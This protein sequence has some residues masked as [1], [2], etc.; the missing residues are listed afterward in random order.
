MKIRLSKRQGRRKSAS[1]E[2]L[3]SPNPRQRNSFSINSSNGNR[4]SKEL[5]KN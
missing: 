3:L 1:Q 5:E 2:N 4:R